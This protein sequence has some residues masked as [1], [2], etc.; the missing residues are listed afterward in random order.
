MDYKFDD[1]NDWMDMDMNENDMYN[2]IWVGHNVAWVN[3]GITIIII[4]IL[5]A[6]TRYL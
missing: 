4:I 5:L 2:E 1:M 6:T 3:A